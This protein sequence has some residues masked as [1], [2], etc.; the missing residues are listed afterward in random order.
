MRYHELKV[1]R[2]LSNPDELC[3]II[4]V[5]DIEDEVRLRLQLERALELAYTDHLTGLLNQQGLLNKC[6]DMLQQDGVQAAVLFMD[7]DN[8]KQVNDEYGHGM[9]D[10]V[11]YEV[12]KAIR[13]ETRGKDIVGRYGGDEFVALINGVKRPHDAEEVAERIAGRVKD[14]CKR[15]K[16][17][18]N[19][20]ASIGISFTSEVGFDYHHLKEIADDRLYLAK[21]QGKNRIVKNSKKSAKK[22]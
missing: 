13:E 1:K 12:G 10:K 8:F 4:A 19:I 9:G 7:L 6:R 20:T 3:A 11:L 14:V 22:G 15:L 21:K 18:I 5:K 16:L 17:A 2:D